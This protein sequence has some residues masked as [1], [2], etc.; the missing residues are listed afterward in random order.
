M[1]RLVQ[2][3]CVEDL[4]ARAVQSES[5]NIMVRPAYVE[6]LMMVRVVQ[7]T[8]LED[9]IVMKVQPASQPACL[10]DLMVRVVQPAFFWRI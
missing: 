6:D 9:L 10:E 8:C 2:P 1:V 5:E 3:D 4:T 7:P